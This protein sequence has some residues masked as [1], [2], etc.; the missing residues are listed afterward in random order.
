MKK[1]F[2][3]FYIL[4]SCVCIGQNF[5]GILTYSM[6]LDISYSLK[7]IGITK[8]M[9]IKDMRKDGTW[10]DQISIY[11]QAGNYFSLMKNDSKTYS[12]YRSDSN[13]LYT[14]FQGSKAII[15]DTSIDKEEKLTNRSPVIKLIDRL[16]VVYGKP[17]KIVRVQWESGF[18]DYYFKSDYLIMDSNL[19]K[20][21]ILNG[22]YGFLKIS[23][24]LPL[25]IIKNSNGVIVTMTL[26]NANNTK[27]D[28]HIFR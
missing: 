12:I 28:T 3:I 6:D 8:E 21:H 4:S 17:C 22:W 27:L 14:F 18:Y 7:K 2:L 9:M 20:G 11:Y 15:L 13:K 25:K 26:I 10:A 23:N 24:A 19:Y 1:V 5:E 16:V